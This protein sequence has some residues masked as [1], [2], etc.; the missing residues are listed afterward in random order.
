MKGNAKGERAA[1]LF[2]DAKISFGATANGGGKAAE[3]VTAV[4]KEGRKRDERGTKEG[5]KRDKGRG[6]A[7]LILVKSMGMWGASA[8]LGV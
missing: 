8:A 2:G 3:G 4:T 6:G 7:Q 5:R 1:P